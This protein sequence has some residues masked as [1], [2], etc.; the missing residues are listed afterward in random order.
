MSEQDQAP[1]AP[2]APP[3]APEGGISA[4][5]VPPGQIPVMSQEPRTFAP[6]P[7]GKVPDKLLLEV[8]QNSKVGRATCPCGAWGV[9]FLRGLETDPEKILDKAHKEWDA[10]PRAT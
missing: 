8:D 10:A 3:A 2:A 9:D 7:C 1:A 6:C 5:Q 4:G